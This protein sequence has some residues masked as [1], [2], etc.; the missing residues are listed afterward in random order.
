MYRCSINIRQDLQVTKLY[1]EDKGTGKM[2][3]TED[4]KQAEKE[5][6]EQ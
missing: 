1:L 4:A 6:E 3:G 5:Y 2:Y